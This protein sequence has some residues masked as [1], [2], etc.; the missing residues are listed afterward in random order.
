VAFLAPLFSASLQRSGISDNRWRGLE[1]AY[2][3]DDPAYAHKKSTLVSAAHLAGRS[4]HVDE[5]AF[6]NGSSD[7]GRFGTLAKFV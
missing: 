5:T 2:P 1:I 3:N 6:G 7:I 4:L